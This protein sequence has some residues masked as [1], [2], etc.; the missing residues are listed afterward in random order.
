MNSRDT[1]YCGV[2]KDKI[3]KRSPKLHGDNFET[4]CYY[5]RERERIRERKELDYPRDSWTDDIILKKYRFTNV[6]RKDDRVSKWLIENISENPNLGLSDKIFNTILFRAY[7]KI[8]T[9]EILRL[10]WEACYGAPSRSVAES[11]KGY[12]SLHPKYKWYGSAYFQSGLKG[13]WVD[14]YESGNSAGR[15]LD[16]LDYVAGENLDELMLSCE[17]QQEVFEVIKT[18]PGFANFLA[19]QV[20]VDLTYIPEFPFTDEEFTVSGPGCN[21]GINLVFSRRDGL[22]DEELIFWLR[23]N[24]EVLDLLFKVTVMDLENCFC[25]ISKYIGFRE[26]PKKRMRKY[27]AN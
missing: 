13:A 2:D 3:S 11:I 4:F 1:P 27:N 19:Y 26:N 25:E 9:A 22:T 12:A 7:N 15:M 21:R 8:E 6:R 16:M 20:F 10:P 23:D 24:Q 14:S 18:I 5:I 17:N